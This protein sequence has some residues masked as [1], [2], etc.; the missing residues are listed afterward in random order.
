M[1]LIPAFFQV[2]AVT[3][4]TPVHDFKSKWGL[5]TCSLQFGFTLTVLMQNSPH[6]NEICLKRFHLPGVDRSQLCQAFL[7]VISVSV[8]SVMTESGPGDSSSGSRV[9]VCVC[10]C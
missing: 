6:F 5:E 8:G 2:T 1:L 10:V 7:T 4:K 3:F 9:C